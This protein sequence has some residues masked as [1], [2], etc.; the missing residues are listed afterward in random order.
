MNDWCVWTWT[1]DNRLL[2]VDCGPHPTRVEVPVAVRDYLD[3]GQ[4]CSLS[5]IVVNTD[6]DT[7]KRVA[8][9]MEKLVV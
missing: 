3:Q 7:A 1:L 8:A 5:F 4:Y 6:E 2:S 9:N